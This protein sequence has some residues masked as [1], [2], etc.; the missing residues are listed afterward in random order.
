MML[1][2]LRILSNSAKFSGGLTLFPACVLF[3]TI[4]STSSN[5]RL[6][7]VDSPKFLGTEN[8]TPILVKFRILDHSGQRYSAE[9]TATYC[10][11]SGRP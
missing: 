6:A 9:S 4:V 8:M 7:S 10:R 11:Q 5:Y 2:N 3:G 1:K